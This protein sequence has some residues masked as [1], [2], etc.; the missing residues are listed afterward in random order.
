MSIAALGSKGICKCRASPF[1]DPQ[2]IIPNAVSV[3]I[4][5]RPI[6]FI[7]PSP[8]IATTISTFSLAAAAAIFSAWQSYN[9]KVYGLYVRQSIL[10]WLFSPVSPR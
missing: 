8:P 2:G 9:H 3:C 7:V 10:I 4:S 5:A 1:P 6:S